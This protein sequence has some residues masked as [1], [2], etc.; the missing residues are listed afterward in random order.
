VTT[1]PIPMVAPA[2]IVRRSPDWPL[3]MTAPAPTNTPSPICTQPLQETWGAK[4]TKSPIKQS[5]DI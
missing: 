5:C 4:V 1:A 3:R 2:P